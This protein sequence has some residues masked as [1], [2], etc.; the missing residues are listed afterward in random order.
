[1]RPRLAV[2]LVLVLAGCGSSPGTSP[3]P[4]AASPDGPPSAAVEDV[5]TGL[6]DPSTIS[7]DAAHVYVVH[8]ASQISR[9]AKTGGG[10]VQI[11]TGQRGP[12]SLD[13]TTD[14]LYWVNTG[15]HSMDF[16]DGS[17]RWSAKTGGA[18][19]ELATS[20]F[21]AALAVDGD[22]VYWVEIDGQRVRQIGTSGTGAMTLDDSPTHKTSIAVTPTRIV[23]TA[24]SDMADV[25][26]MNRV[27]GDRTT[28]STAEYSP[29]SAVVIGDDV[30]WVVRH[31]LSDSG[32][33]RVSR[34][35]AAPVDIVSD[36]YYPAGLVADGSSLYWTSDGR[37]RTVALAGGAAR[38]LVTE[39][40]AI[41]GLAIDAEHVYWSELDRD[42]LVRARLR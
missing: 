33:I 11:A 2:V 36:E 32:S 1:M 28:L 16:R 26:S 3:A 37:I 35:G 13:A 5:A 25:V 15:T 39:R 20:Y 29:G 9:V 19:N 40:G 22:T 17:V 38:S 7:L 34:N 14:R 21:P 8:D 4:D 30:Y 23:W 27:S 18:D 41:G 10:I 42:A 31:A 24:S 6:T 12:S